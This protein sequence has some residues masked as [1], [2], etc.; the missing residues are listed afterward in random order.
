MN[1]ERREQLILAPGEY[2]FASL[3]WENE[4]LGSG[5]LI[6]IAREKLG[7]KKST[8]YTVLRRL[9][10]KGLFINTN[11]IVTS[12]VSQEEV[13][14]AEGKGLLERL[15]S[16]SLPAFVAHFAKKEE[17]SEKELRELKQLIDELEE[18]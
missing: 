10:E 5:E 4:P 9:I 2:S 7:W 6:E 12:L 18:K 15:F 17:L 1:E 14:S 8:S 3:I 13:I 11:S 16:G